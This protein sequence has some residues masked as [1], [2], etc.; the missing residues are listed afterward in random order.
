M[1]TLERPKKE[2]NPQ[3]VLAQSAGRRHEHLETVYRERIQPKMNL[4]YN[5]L[6]QFCIEQNQLDM[7]ISANYIIEGFGRL[8]N[9]RQIDYELEANSLLD[10]GE[11]NCHFVCTG[12]GELGVYVEGKRNIDLFVDIFKIN[13]LQYSKNEVKDNSGNMTGAKLALQRMVPVSFTF[14]ADIDNSEIKLAISNF[15]SLGQTHVQFSPESITEDFI[16]NLLEYMRRRNKGFFNLDLSEIERRRI[17]ARVMYEQQQ[18]QAELEAADKRES[19]IEPRKKGLFSR[20]IG[21]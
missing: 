12:Q 17:R 11:I 18:R 14:R 15:E 3:Q 7:P 6:N 21:R 16:K 20:L 1:S 9:L 8:E 13:G 4:L 19:E 5:S 2:I 10:I